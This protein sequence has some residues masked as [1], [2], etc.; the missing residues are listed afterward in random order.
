MD[1]VKYLSAKKNTGRTIQMSVNGI[2]MFPVLKESEIITI[3][4]D[5]NYKEGDILVYFCDNIGIL[6]HRC[7]KVDNLDYY[8]KGD[9]AFKIEKITKDQ[10]IGKVQ[11]VQRNGKEM[12]IEKPDDE[13]LNMSYEI[14]NIFNRNGFDIVR[15]IG[16]ELYKKYKNKY[17]QGELKNEIAK[18]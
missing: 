18:K 11:T 5:S 2:S 8:C 14:N 15:T 17:L 7:L 3:I 9:N 4:N 1:L 10:I 16:N 6:V 12:S 13:F